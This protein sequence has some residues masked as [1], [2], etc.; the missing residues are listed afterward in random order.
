MKDRLLAAEE[1]YNGR[2]LG[3]TPGLISRLAALPMARFATLAV[4][5]P[6]ILAP[7]AG[8]AASTAVMKGNEV[9]PYLQDVINWQRQA[10]SLPTLPDSAREALLKSALEQTTQQ[11]AKYAFQFAQSQ[12]QLID[13]QEPAE[14][15]N[16]AD[17]DRGHLMAASTRIDAQLSALTSQ[18]NAV[19]AQLRKAPAKRQ[20]MLS[21]KRDELQ[22]QLKLASAQQDLIHN[23]LG[24]F[25]GIDTGPGSSLSGKVSSLANS[26]LDTAKPPA[27]AADKAA[28]TATPAIS[29]PLP[30]PMPAPATGKATASPSKGLF[31]M[32]EEVFKLWREITAVD[33]LAK[34]TNDLNGV[35]KRYL[36]TLRTSLRDAVQ[37]GTQA[38]QPQPQAAA[39]PSTATVAAPQ[40]PSQA[41]SN[42]AATK[43]AQAEKQKLD[44]LLVNF[45]QLSAGVVPLSQM[46]FW[47]GS[48]SR[49]LDDWTST[50]HDEIATLLRALLVRLAIL[51]TTIAVP[52]VLSALVKRATE[53]YVRDE[54]RRKQLRAVR[55]GLVT[56]AI[57]VIVLL[58]LV[59][60]FGSFATFA[61][62][63]VGGLAV[64]FQNVLL[65]IV[66]HFFF[67]GRYS[68]RPGDRVSVSGVIGDV[69]YVGVIRFYMKELDLVDG[70]LAATGRVA[71]FPNSILF[72]TSAFFKYVTD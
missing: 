68:V 3:A 13:A 70:K 56:V 67:Y 15:K 40:S 52:L 2:V 36:Q 41:A 58:N 57:I 14:T 43:A 59:T 11:V 6:L 51:A 30:I 33:D 16:D 29:I 45:K 27:A 63:I 48:S 65:S 39:G 35:N 1:D 53:R 55:R 69:V 25:N 9:L 71:A 46:N 34:L 42:D 44:D 72:Q 18:L 21:A 22:S 66:A 24:I 12:A 64:A 38:M 8:I 26:V 62:F 54:K 5:L 19:N 49:N 60:Q 50:L 37:Q 20:A 7:A 23:V 10:A 4:L 47:L 61:G 17:G 28:D 32:T 31:E